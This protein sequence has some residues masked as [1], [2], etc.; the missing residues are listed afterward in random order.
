MI[1]P[2]PYTFEFSVL[3]VGGRR[4]RSLLKCVSAAKDKNFD[5]G[6]FGMADIGPYGRHLVLPLPPDQPRCRTGDAS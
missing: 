6:I 3:D 5:A 1:W 2:Y 4:Y